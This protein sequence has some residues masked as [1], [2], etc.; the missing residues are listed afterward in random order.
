MSYH[1][2]FMWF[3]AINGILYVLYAILS[4]EWRC[5]LRTGTRGSGDQVTLRSPLRKEAPPQVT[6]H[7]R[8][9]RTAIIL[10]GSD[11]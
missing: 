5:L 11:R 3:F 6:Y 7:P 9:D 8:S 10:T 1:F 2:F 4:G